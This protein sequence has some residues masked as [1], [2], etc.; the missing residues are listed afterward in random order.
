R[1]ER[2]VAALANVGIVGMAVEVRARQPAVPRPVVLRICGGVHADISAARLDVA[3]EVV[4]LRR[5]QDVTRRTQEDDRAVSRQDLMGEGAGI[6][7]RVDRE[8]VLLP[9]LPECGDA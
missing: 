2:A 4:L 1:V 3:L 7:G 9:K 5:I 6:L 8:S